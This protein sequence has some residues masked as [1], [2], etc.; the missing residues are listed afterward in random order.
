MCHTHV[1]LHPEADARFSAAFDTA[2]A[3]ERAKADTDESRSFEQLQADGFVTLVSGARCSS[4]RRPAEIAVLADLDTLRHGLHSN[5]VCE[6][7]DGQPVPPET[8]RRLACDGDVIPVVLDSH[9]AVLDHGHAR[10]M[11]T[12]EQRRALLAMC[13]TC[14]HPHCIVRFGD[15]EIHHVIEWLRQ[16]DPPTWRI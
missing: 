4:G 6:T 14:A 13:R 8:V 11:A 5:T 9:G 7:F 10:R 16:A 12:T 2:V 1:A 3:T 15:C